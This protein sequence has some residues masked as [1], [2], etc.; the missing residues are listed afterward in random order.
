MD[1]LALP[2]TYDGEDMKLPLKMYA[3]S[4]TFRVEVMTGEMTVKE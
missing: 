4:Y 1:E 3:Y 2:L